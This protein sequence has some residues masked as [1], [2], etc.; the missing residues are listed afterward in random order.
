[1][2]ESHLRGQA[3]GT[4]TREGVPVL[5]A[6]KHGKARV[7]APLLRLLGMTVVTVDVDTDRFGTFSGEIPRV[8]SAL[9]A[10]RAKIDAAFA[11]CPSVS[12]A[13]ASEGSFGPHPVSPWLPWA[14]E[15]VLYRERDS[16]LEVCGEDSGTATNHAQARCASPEDGLAFAR[17]CGFPDHGVIVMPDDGARPPLKDL[18]DEPS[19][20]A[21]LEHLLRAQGEV[22][23]VTDMRAHR[24]PTRM[25][26]IG[27]AAQDLVQR[28]RTSCPVCERPGFGLSGHERGLPCAACGAPTRGYRAQILRCAGC[29][30]TVRRALAAALADPGACDWCNP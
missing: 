16:D 17:R 23:L 1:M 13:L 12:R 5:L 30:H 27:R 25:A 6:T 4:D 14:Q 8:G 21:A 29:G 3:D 22:T 20:R 26:A 18:A 28:L 24:N 19:L 9:D 7:I 15:L 10:A 2:G 11:C